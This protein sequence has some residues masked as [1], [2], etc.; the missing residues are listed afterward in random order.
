MKFFI[1]ELSFILNN[2]GFST[3][4]AWAHPYKAVVTVTHFGADLGMRL[5]LTI[6]LVLQRYAITSVTNVGRPSSSG[7]TFLSTRCV[8]R[9]P[10]HCSKCGLGTSYDWDKVQLISPASA[11]QV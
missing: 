6:P 3:V 9:E 1:S 7:S 4:V 2:F 5:V 10:S 11:P 8:T